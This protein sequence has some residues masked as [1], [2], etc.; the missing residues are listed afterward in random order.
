MTITELSPEKLR[1][2]CPPGQVGCETSAELGPVEGIIGQDRALKALKF[3]IEM[4][5]KGFNVYAAGPPITGK[6]PATR[7]FLEAIAKTR[8]VPSDWAYVNN[9][10]NQYEPKALM[11]PPGK[12]RVFQKD[13][14]NFIEQ[15]KRAIPAT[16]QSEEFVS[17][18][19]NTTKKAVTDRN[20]ILNDL[21]KRAETL[22]YT[23]RMTQLGITIVP[24]VAGKPVSQEDFDSL[25]ARV[26]KK[27]EQTRDTMRAAL[28]NAGKGINDLDMTTVEELKKLRDDS[29]HYAIG[30]LMNS[31]TSR[32]QD[33]PKVLQHLNEVRDDIL[34]NAEVFT[35]GGAA[36]EK[37]DEEQR[38]PVESK[39]SDHAFRRYEVNV[40]VDN[41]EL[42]GAPVI[43][44]DNPTATNLLGKIEYESRF[45]ALVTDFTLIKAGSLHR[46]NGGFLVVGVDEL[47]K[48]QFSYD[49]L[50]RALQSASLQ[51]ED[52]GQRLGGAPTKTPVP[53]PIP[54][55]VKIILVGDHETYQALYV[56]DP[57]FSILFKV[58]AHFDDSIERND[59]NQKTYGSFVHSLCEREGLGHLDAPALA[60]IVEYGSR[61]AE[62]QTKL[63]TKF[64]QIAD[65]IREA[66]FYASQE[67][68]KLVRE[69]HIKK[70]L[71]EKVY[72]SNLLDE[73]V[74]EMIQRGIIL[75]D[76]SGSK[77]GQVNG[78][79]VI[80]LGDFDFGQPS[81]ITASLGLGRRGIID[82]ERESKLGG[83]I[84]TKGVLIISGYLENKY[85]REKPLSLS[86]RLVFE[87]SYGSVDGD[88]AS[89]TELYAILSALAELPIKQNLAVTGSVNQEGEVQAIGGVNEK[90][91]GFYQTC[92]VKGLKGD[93]GV[94]IP[95]SNTQH[96]MLNE[97]VV[98]A[99]RKGR[100]HIYPVGTIDEGIEIL[101]GVKAGQLKKDGTYEPGTVH[102]RVN[103]R[104]AEMTQSMARLVGSARF[105]DETRPS[106]I[107][108]LAHPS[109]KP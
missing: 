7:S 40:I 22:G 77:V 99:V 62:D 80:G 89:S 91:E 76:T 17:R 64:P 74:K 23:V 4:K 28:D 12:A 105:A 107:G 55:S 84:H 75:I 30:G 16:L 72:R 109:S 82:I 100:F 21:N 48:N 6:R 73:K 51:L 103:K 68:S 15:A 46:A 29:V 47:L 101:T 50:K 88:S 65:L 25:P 79:S 97:D 18:T 3:G 41:S 27:Y 59:K 11:F 8:P 83:Q 43:A 63:S 44:E 26:K 35:E 86:C 42:K 1:L 78:L 56:L 94:I 85:A 2:E 13:L 108:A 57:D 36:E 39:L 104:L 81:R 19:N 45:G 93:E 53:E 106:E 14:K 67:G 95:K 9:F 52:M 66:S 10:Q 37:P 58:K 49:G 98:D 34:E 38:N 70:A 90:I 71:D 31:L 20:K 33:L 24:V 60:R 87:Q 32:Y 5:G 92:K 69:V 54:L 102:Y 61:L 96:L